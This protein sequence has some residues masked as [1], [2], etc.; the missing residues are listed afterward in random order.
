[1]EVYKEANWMTKEQ[2]LEN[3]GGPKTEA[4]QQ[5]D[6]Y[7]FKKV[8]APKILFLNTFIQG[9]VRRSTLVRGIYQLN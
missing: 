8:W 3:G 4:E 9:Y 7:K 6:V 1:M 5:M 2:E